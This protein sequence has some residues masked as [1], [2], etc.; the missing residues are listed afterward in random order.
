MRQRF[1][2]S[3]QTDY[4][5]NET[6]SH[7]SN[8]QITI[9]ANSFE[10]AKQMITNVHDEDHDEQCLNFNLVRVE[11]IIV[12]N[13][14]EVTSLMFDTLIKIKVLFE[15][16]RSTIKH[17][18]YILNALIEQR[19]KDSSLSTKEKYSRQVEYDS[20]LKDVETYNKLLKL[21]Q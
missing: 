15:D 16:E 13:H 3:Y 19:I 8:R 9:T 2:I 20:L 6:G 21:T 7:K 18:I 10:H 1:T 14:Q 11:D 4:H 17:D 12:L 5:C